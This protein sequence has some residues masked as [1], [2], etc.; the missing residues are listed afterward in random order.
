MTIRQEQHQ[1]LIMFIFKQSQLV[2]FA[3]YF[4][5]YRAFNIQ[6]PTILALKD[7]HI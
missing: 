1:P 2:K 3:I 5:W 7:A 4:P 6:T